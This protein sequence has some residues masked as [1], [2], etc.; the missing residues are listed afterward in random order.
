MS[1][2]ELVAKFATVPADGVA[3]I[4]ADISAKVASDGVPS[5]DTNNL[6]DELKV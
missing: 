1:V 2:S 5:M 3:A 6:M 4:A